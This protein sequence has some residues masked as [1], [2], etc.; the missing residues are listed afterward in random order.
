MLMVLCI[1]FDCGLWLI[2]MKILV[3]GRVVLVLVLVLCIC[4]LVIVVF[5]FIVIMVWLVRNCILLLLWV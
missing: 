4:K 1:K 5:L 2:V 3:I